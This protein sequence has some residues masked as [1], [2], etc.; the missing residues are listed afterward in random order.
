MTS[1]SHIFSLATL[2]VPDATLSYRIAGNGTSKVLFIQGVGVAGCGWSPQ[3]DALR[4]SHHVCAFDHRGVGASTG[5][6]TTIES[7]ADDAVRIMDALNWNDAHLV[8]H[9]MGSSVALALA[10]AHRK[11][12]RSLALLCGLARGQHVIRFEPSTLW[13]QLSCQIGTLAMRRRA[14]FRLV[15]PRSL[16]D[17]EDEIRKL[18]AIFGRSL[19]ALPAVALQQVSALRNFD[20]Y[21]TLHTLRDLPTLVLSATD[22]IVCPPAD[23]A[24]L[25]SA[26]DT[27]FIEVPGGHAV[28][29]Q[30]ARRIN[31]LLGDHLTRAMNLG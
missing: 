17:R 3:L 15:S 22:D 26:L 30:D 19:T 31:Q 10:M 5:S 1:P 11:R 8:G 6:P 9:S 14:F 16:W 20:V 21:D 28:V 13:R 29:V 23:G 7:M 4:S 2:S 24:R 25:A 18:E 27:P 12:V